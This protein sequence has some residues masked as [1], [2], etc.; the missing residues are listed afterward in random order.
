VGPAY[1]LA[2]T[3][4]FNADNTLLS[5]GGYTATNWPQWLSRFEIGISGSSNSGATDADCARFA[6]NTTEASLNGTFRVSEADC[7]G[8][9]ANG[10]GGPNDGVY[11]RATFNRSQLGTAENLMAVLEYV[12]SAY[13]PAPANI[14]TCMSSGVTPE[15][16]AENTWKTF[17]KHSVSDTSVQPFLM[18]VPPSQNFYSASTQ[19]ITNSMTKQFVIPLSSDPALS[20]LQISRIQSN[21]G[22]NASNCSNLSIPS[23]LCSGMVIYSLTLYRI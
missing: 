8:T 9:T 14:A 21:L 17:V 3:Q 7:S 18:L 12:A 19:V 15:N 11:L 2:A 22:A 20:V 5:S 13:S 23:A 6:D 4:V 10:T 16:C 1:G